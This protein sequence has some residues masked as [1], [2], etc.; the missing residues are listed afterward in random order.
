MKGQEIDLHS[1]VATFVHDELAVKEEY[2]LYYTV[3]IS[4][5]SINQSFIDVYDVS[6]YESQTS[7]IDQ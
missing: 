1:R 4:Y 7:M 6:Q 2:S 5:K 3:P